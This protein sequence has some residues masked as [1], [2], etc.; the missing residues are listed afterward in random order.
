MTSDFRRGHRAAVEK[1][2]AHVDMMIG[3]RRE[4]AESDE[5]RKTLGPGSPTIPGLQDMYAMRDYLVQLAK[6]K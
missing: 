4:W 1:M 3:A 2:M 6:I 5:G